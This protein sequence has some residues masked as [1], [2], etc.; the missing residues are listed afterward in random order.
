[1]DSGKNPIAYLFRFGPK[2]LARHIII[3]LTYRPEHAEPI[4][5]ELLEL[6]RGLLAPVVEDEALIITPPTRTQYAELREKIR[7]VCDN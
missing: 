7:T 4:T 5:A 6:Q 3:F 2:L 1:M